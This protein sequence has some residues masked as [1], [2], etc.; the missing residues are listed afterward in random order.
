M[1]GLCFQNRRTSTAIQKKKSLDPCVKIGKYVS[2]VFAKEFNSNQNFPD[3]TEIA[4]PKSFFYG[5]PRGLSC[6]IGR[7]SMTLLIIKELPRG[8]VLSQVYEQ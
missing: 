4:N 5:S 2:T 3:M 1:G 7:G 6:K 8:V